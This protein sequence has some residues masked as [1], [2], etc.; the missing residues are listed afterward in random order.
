MTG[1]VD[2]VPPS[3]DRKGA[4]RRT[5]RLAVGRERRPSVSGA[6]AIP[7]P[8]S[9]RDGAF[10]KMRLPATPNAADGGALDHSRISWPS[11]RVSTRLGMGVDFFELDCP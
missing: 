6:A 10:S 4:R 3:A 7:L 11:G 9:R 1:S 8:A 2:A 5:A